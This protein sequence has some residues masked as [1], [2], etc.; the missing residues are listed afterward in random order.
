MQR[1]VVIGFIARRLRV[2]D[3]DAR[4]PRAAEI[5]VSRRPGGNPEPL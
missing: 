4:Q 3:D 2:S 5:Q 1:G